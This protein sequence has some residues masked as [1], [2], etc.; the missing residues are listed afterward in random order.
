[1]VIS[2]CFSASQ[3]ETKKEV[4]SAISAYYAVKKEIP[5]LSSYDHGEWEKDHLARGNDG[6]GSAQ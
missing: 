2:F 4:I 6:R 1:M 3:R 5:A